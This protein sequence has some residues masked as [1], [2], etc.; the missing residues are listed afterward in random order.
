MFLTHFSKFILLSIV[1]VFSVMSCTHFSLYFPW[2]F[3]N[4]SINWKAQSCLFTV[5]DLTDLSK[6]DRQVEKQM[7]GWMS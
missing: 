5:K 7:F 2:T 6:P 4:K 1:F 3:Q